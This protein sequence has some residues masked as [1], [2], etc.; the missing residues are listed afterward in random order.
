MYSYARIVHNNTCYI[1]TGID[2]KPVHHVSFLPSKLTWGVSIVSILLFLYCDCVAIAKG[3]DASPVRYCTRLGQEQGLA[4]NMVHSVLQDSY[5]F[6]WF[7]TRYGLSRYDG[8]SFTTYSSPARKSSGELYLAPISIEA[9]CLSK[10]GALWV[11]TDNGGIDRIDPISG[12][13]RHYLPESANTFASIVYTRSVCVDS[14]GY[15]W[16]TTA[17]ADVALKRLDPRTGKIVRYEHNA[18]QPHSLSSRDIT[19]VCADSSGAVWVGTLNAGLNLYNPSND[20]FVNAFT[21]PGFA[22]KEIANAA[23]LSVSSTGDLWVMCEGNEEF[24][25]VQKHGDN[26]SAVRILSGHRALKD[27]SIIC[28]STDKQGNIWAGTSAKGMYLISPNGRSYTHYEYNAANP[29]GLPGNRVAAIMQDS[30]G[31]MWVCTDAGIATFNRRSMAIHNYLGLHE[32][33]ALREI[34]SLLAEDDGSVW[35]GTG[36]DG[37]FRKKN[38]VYSHF[39]PAVHNTFNSR[40]VNVL[41]RTSS[42]ELFV[43]TNDGLYLLDVQNKRYVPYKDVLQ[44]KRRRVWSL[45]EDDQHN[46]WVGLLH[47]GVWILDAERSQYK[48]LSLL[49]QSG[50]PDSAKLDIFCIHQ[51]RSGTIWLGSNRGVYALDASTRRLLRHYYY[52]PDDP[53]HSIS[54][55][56]VWSICETEDAKLWMGTSGGGVTVLDTKR[57]TFEWLNETQGL[58]NNVVAAVMPGTHN[59]V[60]IST[61]HG[62]SRYVPQNKRFF[63]F[64]NWDGVF[65]SRFHFKSNCKRRGGELLFGGKDGYIEFHPDSILTHSPPPRVFITALRTFQNGQLPG[66]SLMF[67]RRATELRHDQNFFTLELVLTDLINPKANCFRYKL[68]GIDVDWQES[69]GSNPTVSYTSLSPGTYIFNVMGANSD[70]VWTTYTQQLHIHIQAAW[71]QNWIFRGAAFIFGVATISAFSYWRLRELKNKRK[72]ERSIAEFRLQAVRARMNP[73]FIFNT[74]NSIVGF[75]LAND[76]KKAHHYLTKFSRLMRAILEHSGAE[77][78]SLQDEI[79]I[80]RWYIELEQMRYGEKFSYDIHVEN[81]VSMNVE[82]PSMILQPLVENSIKHG[83]IHTVDGGRVDIFFRLMGEQLCCEVRDN[84][85]GRQQSAETKRYGEYHTSRGLTLVLERLAVLEYLDDN[86][87]SMD[88]RDAFP[89]AQYPG[90]YISLHFPY[91]QRNNSEIV[92]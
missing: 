55:N 78:I 64:G 5:G 15:V 18:Q 44:R 68:E 80:L 9:L 92:Q 4:D 31:N 6:L 85:I 12:N 26:L 7:G 49:A 27:N 72:A 22:V 75:I 30:Y 56:H 34:R 28:V 2:K 79:R 88:V 69:K 8:N 1:N 20:S 67:L 29:W 43:G 83:L 89:G 77:Y 62:L 51:A 37:V 38:G 70:G 35:I 57:E 87:Y 48:E 32:G 17:G 33:I 81:E 84:G 23:R 59:D 36:G 11:G 19:F 86:T 41:L 45:L 58:A 73:H 76:A 40:T 71:W 21:T 66:D 50:M 60:W 47:V 82:L 25:R 39:L 91:R 13:V 10:D 90:T 46:I 3:N 65:V 74:I 63:N 61:I 16:Y 14:A 53:T 42:G 52:N 24:Y 54:Y